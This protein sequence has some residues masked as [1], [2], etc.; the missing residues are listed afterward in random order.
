MTYR[1]VCMAMAALQVLEAT[2]AQPQGEIELSTSG[3]RR[4]W[5]EFSL[6]ADLSDPNISGSG[7]A[8]FNVN[9][10]ELGLQANFK[11]Q[12]R[13]RVSAHVGYAVALGGKYRDTGLFDLLSDPFNATL[14]DNYSCCC[15][16]SCADSTMVPLVPSSG[17]LGG[18]AWQLSA[19]L[20]YLL[21]LNEV[22]SVIPYLGW[23][24][25]TQRYAVHDGSWGP[26]NLQYLPYANTETFD[27]QSFYEAMAPIFGGWAHDFAANLAYGVPSTSTVQSHP[28]FDGS[29]SIIGFELLGT[30]PGVWLIPQQQSACEVPFTYFGHCP[31]SSRYRAAWNGPLLGLELSFA[32]SRDW[33]AA[34][35]YELQ[36]LLFSGSYSSI[37]KSSVCDSCPQ[38][39]TWELNDVGLA[40]FNQCATFCPA[41]IRWHSQGWGQMVYATL[42]C[43]CLESLQ[44]GLRLQYSY[45]ASFG[46][47]EAVDP[48]Q[49]CCC[50]VN[51]RSYNPGSAEYSNTSYPIWSNAQA[52]NSRWQSLSIQFSCGCEF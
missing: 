16:G 38:F 23:S 50:I 37:G 9:M 43:R 41:D 42:G 29:G 17:C 47:A 2:A 51:G 22:L 20:G 3:Y 33:S 27:G 30:G 11:L 4:D 21:P 49:S 46:G 15:P 10:W 24:Y 52:Y 35:G 26:I 39:V 32:T 13:L 48:C 31:N 36:Y 44:C 45:A 19:N 6:C 14:G 7:T 8:K 40:D 25:N 12:E 5:A 34:L 28:I 1:S 18:N